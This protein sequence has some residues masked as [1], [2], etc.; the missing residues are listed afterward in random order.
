[1]TNTETKLPFMVSALLAVGAWLACLLSMLVMGLASVQLAGAVL[2]GFA[3]VFALC[4]LVM[5]AQKLFFPRPGIYVDLWLPLAWLFAASAFQLMTAALCFWFHGFMSRRRSRGGWM[6]FVPS[7]LM[8]AAYAAWSAVP[9][10]GVMAASTLGKLLFTGWVLLYFF[11]GMGVWWNWVS[12]NRKSYSSFCGWYLIHL[13][14][15]LA[16]CIHIQV[17]LAVGF[18]VF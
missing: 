9:H 10:R 1:M 14:L 5:L 13:G 4:G 2:V 12:G 16:V 11:Q 17:L 15:L 6:R 8:V 7:V 3:A 18:I